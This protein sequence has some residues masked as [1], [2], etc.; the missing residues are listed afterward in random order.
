MWISEWKICPRCEGRQVFCLQCGR[1]GGWL[2]ARW[3]KSEWDGLPL[4]D[5]Q[6]KPTTDY[7]TSGR[8]PGIARV[9]H[10]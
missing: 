7:P 5:R 1:S 10:K 4:F 3:I 6:N 9:G 2:V 8:W